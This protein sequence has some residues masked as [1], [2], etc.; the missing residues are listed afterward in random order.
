MIIKRSI[1]VEKETNDLLKNYFNTC[2]RPLPEKYTTPITLIELMGGTSTDTIDTF[3][4]RLS[5][6]AKTNGEA[7]TTMRNVL[8]V[9]DYQTKNQVGKLCYS[10]EEN[11]TS[12]GNDPIRP[13]LCLCT[14][15]VQVIAHKESFEIEES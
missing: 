2:L 4:I 6:R 9:L 5:V 1:D 3:T 8:G 12:W 10:T 7:V 13:D 14:A 15:T 11:L